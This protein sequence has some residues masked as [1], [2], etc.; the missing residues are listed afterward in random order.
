MSVKDFHIQNIKK[1]FVIIES[2]RFFANQKFS[3][4]K[5]SGFIKQLNYVATNDNDEDDQCLQ[6]SE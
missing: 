6:E 2:L 4:K 5:N 3:K 1:E